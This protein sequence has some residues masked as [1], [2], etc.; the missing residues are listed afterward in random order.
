MDTDF[1]ISPLRRAIASLESGLAQQALAPTEELLRDGCI[2]R[3]EFVYELSHKML[4]R[5]L[6]I[7][8]P[9]PDDVEALTFADLIRT[10]DE[11][12]LLLNGWPRWKA[13]RDARSIS[14]HTY[15]ERKAREVFMIIPDFL[16]EA[17]HLEKR[18]AASLGA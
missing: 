1:D 7:I 3:F 14:S 6:K 10:G 8:S 2:Q 12:G 16:A 4:R 13:F 9:S 15:D 17:R 18:L 11:R 5:F